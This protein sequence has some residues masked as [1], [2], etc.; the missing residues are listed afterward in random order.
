MSAILENRGGACEVLLEPESLSWDL[1]SSREKRQEL[2]GRSEG[3]AQSAGF[4][5][6]Q[7]AGAG[8]IGY[9]EENSPTLTADYHNP[10]VMCMSGW[11][12]NSIVS[13]EMCGTLTAHDARGGVVHS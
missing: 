13:D 4:K 6:H 7:G 5:F 10:A 9:E 3:C 12:A 1:K 2:A 8:N 11:Q